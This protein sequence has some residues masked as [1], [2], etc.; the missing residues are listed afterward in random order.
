[1]TTT[2]LPVPKAKRAALR[3]RKVLVPLDF[4]SAS[5]NAFKYALKIAQQVGAQLT[6]L[7]VIRPTASPAFSTLT[8]TAVLFETDLAT[9][10]EALRSLVAM[11]RTAGVID[12]QS[13]FRV[14]VAAH[15]IVEE[16]KE[17][18]A[19]LIVIAT[20]G[21]TGWKHYCIGSTAER[22]VRAAPCPVL[23]VREKE[24]EF[25]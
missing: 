1:M 12:A 11:A 5:T 3:I 14:G 22:V 8:E 4:S 13:T 9:S 18:D 2:T 6:L 17:L 24:Y 23:V 25:V 19:D 15:E 10:E 20:H 16:A 21:F 7:H